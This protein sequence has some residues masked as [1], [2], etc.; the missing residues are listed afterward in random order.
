MAHKKLLEKLMY[1]KFDNLSLKLVESYLNNRYQCV[2]YNGTFSEYL[3]VKHGVPQGSVLGPILFIIYIN[4]L[5]D[6]VLHSALE[7]FLFADDLAIS[8]KHPNL[9]LAVNILDSKTS[10]IKDWCA[11]NSLALNEEK[12]QDMRFSLSKCDKE[13]VKNN[14]KFLGVYIQSDL[15][16]KVHTDHVQKNAVKVYLC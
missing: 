15:T 2:I 6:S 12:T 13:I 4:D 7:A 10:V 5:P 3:P 14:V 8:V 9:D 11:A 16:W 1:Y